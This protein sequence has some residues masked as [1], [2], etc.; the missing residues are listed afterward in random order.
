MNLFTLKSYNMKAKSILPIRLSFLLLLFSVSNSMYAFEL[1]CP[2]DVTIDCNADI[3]DLSAYGNAQYKDYSGWHDAG[4]PVVTYDLNHC[5]QGDIIRTW[6]VYNPYGM[7]NETCSQIISVGDGSTFSEANI[8]WPL[9][10][11]QVTGCNPD[12]SPEALPP[13]YQ[14]PTWTEGPCSMIGYSYSDKTFQLSGACKKVVREWEL[15]NCC[16]FNV[17]TGHGIFKF[18]Q[19]IDVTVS[20]LPELTCPSDITVGTHECDGAFVDVD[21][22]EIMQSECSDVVQIT[23]DSPFANE[24]KEDAS[25]FYPIG[26]TEVTFIASLGCSDTP[27][28]CKINVTVIDETTPT[29]YCYYGLSI[30]LMGIDSDGDGTNDEGM[31]EVWA[32]DLDVGSYASCED[33]EELFFSFSS[34]PNDNV[35]IFTCDD[36]GRNDVEMWVT[37]E[38]GQQSYCNTYIRVQ[39]NAAEIEDC[40]DSDEYS[41]LSGHLSLH[42]GGHPGNVTLKAEGTAHEGIEMPVMTFEVIETYTDSFQNASGTWIY[43]YSIDTV[44]TET[45]EMVYPTTSTYL[46]NYGE[47]YEF[48]ELPHYH[49]Y[50]ISVVSDDELT[51]RVNYGDVVE[52][53]AYL[54]GFVDFSPYQKMAADINQ[55]GNITNEDYLIL[56]NYVKDPTTYDLDP[57]WYF[58]DS[59]ISMEEGETYENESTVNDL[60]EDTYKVNLVGLRLGDVTDI[61]VSESSIE[62]DFIGADHDTERTFEYTIHP[63]PFLQDFVLDIEHPHKGEATFILKDQSGVVIMTKEINLEKTSIPIQLPKA[64]LSGLYLYEIQTKKEVYSGKII[65]I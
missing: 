60:K 37:D 50:S 54:E 65:K 56:F 38:N 15:I 1:V 52:L 51:S 27:E 17:Y 48:P 3:Y 30:A 44:W 8:N 21:L 10:G 4:Y 16:D 43:F 13:G 55:D 23:N 53:R 22:I 2:A 34:D 5:D 62:A 41:T 28:V 45:T 46:E 12:L 42:Y 47:I 39:N 6:T 14:Q 32:S 40:E 18:F 9:T 33:D 35:R 36:V 11:L 58:Y 24:N 57:T 59:N 61:E 7:V 20:D 29:P 63:N 49:D 25:G 26:T 64:I 19:E 31:V